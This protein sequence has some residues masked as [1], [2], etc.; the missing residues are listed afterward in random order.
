M[1]TRNV[2]KNIFCPAFGV[3]DFISQYV[4]SKDFS[5]IVFIF[6]IILPRVKRAVVVCPDVNNFKPPNSAVYTINCSLYFWKF[7][8]NKKI[9]T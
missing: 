4:R 8:H 9:K 3:E 1:I 5:E 7:W 6:Y 2:D